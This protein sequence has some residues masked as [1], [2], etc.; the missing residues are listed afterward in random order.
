MVFNK[1]SVSF[2]ESPAHFEEV[3]QGLSS[4]VSMFVVVVA[5]I[6]SSSRA[7]DWE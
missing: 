7:E 2:F 6:I 3:R 4:F 1:V 5:V